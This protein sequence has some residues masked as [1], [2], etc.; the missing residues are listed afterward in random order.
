MHCAP[1]FQVVCT[2]KEERLIDCTFPENFSAPSDAELPATP[3]IPGIPGAFCRSDDTHRF[4]VVC[5]RFEIN[6]AGD[7][8]PVCLCWPTHSLPSS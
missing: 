2:G 3:P 7:C 6:G 1:C 4:S 5:R 8:R